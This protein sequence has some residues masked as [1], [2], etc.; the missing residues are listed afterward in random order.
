MGKVEKVTVV[1]GSTWLRGTDGSI[2]RIALYVPEKKLARGMSIF[3][4][5]E[6]GLDRR[7]EAE[8]AQWI[9]SPGG[10]GQWRLSK[11]LSYNFERGSVESVEEMGYPYLESP[12]L[13]ERGIRKP[14]EMG[15]TELARYIGKLNAAGIKDTRLIVDYQVKISYPFMNVFMMVL[16]LALSGM[17]RTGGGLFAAGIGIS[18]SFTYWLLYTFMLSMGYAR[19][20]PPVVA[21]WIVPVLFAIIAACV[22]LRVPE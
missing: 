13:F 21:P 12:T 19:V 10:K 8:E 5:G 11:V 7:I 6:N 9:E 17:R 4:R 15:I 14:E 18:L 20:I 22:F 1:E 2:V 16:G 3:L